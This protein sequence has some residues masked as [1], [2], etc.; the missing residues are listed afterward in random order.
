MKG[1]I[2]NSDE[3]R[4]ARRVR[5]ERKREAKRAERLV[6]CTLDNVASIESLYEASVKA[7]NGIRW[8]AS[9]QRF[10]LDT[11]G[12]V[13]KI[14]NKL[15]NGEDIHT[16][17]TR[18]TINERGKLRD[19]AAVKFPERVAQ[20]AANKYAFMPSVRPTLIYD[21]SA[22]VKG[23]GTHFAVKR[24][25]KH[26]ADH[27]RRHG[28]EGYILIGDYKG[29]FA[30]IPHDKAKA[31]VREYLEDEAL[32]DLICA[33]IDTQDGDRGLSL[34][35]EIN[36]TLAVSYPS[37]IDH[38]VL[39]CGGVEAYGRYM[40]DFYAIHSSKEHLKVILGCIE[41]MSRDLGLTL[42]AN[43]THI[44]KL[45]HGFIYLKRKFSYGENGRVVV[46]PARDTITRERR[47]LKKQARLVASG[48]MT[49]EQAH[50]SYQ[51]WRGHVLKMDA[52]DL[53]LR[54]DALFASLFKE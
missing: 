30:S 48:K 3:R 50:L 54:M 34:G 9:V 25:K 23:K 6:D 21:N 46:R 44:V 11:V 28:S 43:K 32:I 2:L 22:N 51:S 12:N 29:F 38:F 15:L 26:L 49:F 33:Q 10:H 8:K 17:F 42:N 13:L 31:L 36:Q 47:K 5:R 27:Y 39:E 53:I 4:A 14:K 20:K 18:F 24:L 7:A 35:S 16:G 45:T 1:T 52:H 40:D 19:I 37:R 41:A